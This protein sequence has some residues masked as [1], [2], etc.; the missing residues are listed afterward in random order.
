[1]KIALTISIIINIVL[2]IL[3]KKEHY[4]NFCNKERLRRWRMKTL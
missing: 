2:L 4:E 3:W 1:M